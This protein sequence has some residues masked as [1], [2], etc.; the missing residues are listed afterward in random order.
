MKKIMLVAGIVFAIGLIGILSLGITKEG[1]TFSAIFGKEV[2][3]DET[4]SIAADS[5]QKI[6]VAVGSTD[7]N[8]MPTNGNDIEVH[9]YGKGNKEGINTMKFDVKQQGDQLLIATGST[10]FIGVQYADTT[11]DIRLPQKLYKKIEVNGSSGD[12]SIKELKADTIQ[13]AASSGHIQAENL[14]GDMKFKL[15]SGKVDISLE[16]ITKD[17]YVNASSGDIN[18]DVK[19]EPTSL[20]LDFNSSSGKGKVDLPMNYETKTGNRIYGKLGSGEHTVKVNMSSGDFH[21]HTK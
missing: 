20:V 11:L 12:M 5:I 21:F 14:E 1:F 9:L 15:S 19:Q 4:K 13:V 7:V 8:I 18:L 17:I 16:S 3:I 10:F 2:T 6:K